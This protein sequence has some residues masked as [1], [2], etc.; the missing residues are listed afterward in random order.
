M[1]VDNMSKIIEE[2][3]DT[4][5]MELYISLTSPSPKIDYSELTLEQTEALMTLT[6]LLEKFFGRIIY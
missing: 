3:K 6:S 5:L 2:L 4:T 1:S